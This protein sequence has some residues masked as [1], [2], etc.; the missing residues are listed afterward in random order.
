MTLLYWPPI[1]TGSGLKHENPIE[2][3][4]FYIGNAKLGSEDDFV[5]S[6]DSTYKNMV[7]FYMLKPEVNGYVSWEQKLST[8]EEE[9]FSKSSPTEIAKTHKINNVTTFV[10]PRSKKSILENMAFI[11]SVD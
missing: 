3:K 1:H 2:F 7:L 8:L 5:H 6:T 11:A 9:G 10:M 4:G